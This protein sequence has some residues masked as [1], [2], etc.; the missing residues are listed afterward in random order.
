MEQYKTMSDPEYAFIQDFLMIKDGG[1]I[2]KSDMWEA[3]VKWCKEKSL[4]MTPKNML[5]GKLSN[6]LPEMRT[7]RKR[8]NGVRELI[9]E[10]IAWNGE[11]DDKN[12]YKN[13]GINKGLG[14]WNSENDDN[15][16][17][18]REISEN[19][20]EPWTANQQEETS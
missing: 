3:Y 1:Y 7:G 11:N 17:K 15:D 5:T 8:I 4:P 19:Q 10:N 12:K 13:S 16:N 2:L 14:R 18:N 20:D 9:F 6:H